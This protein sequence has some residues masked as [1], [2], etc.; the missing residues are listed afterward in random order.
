LRYLKAGQ[1]RLRTSVYAEHGISIQELEQRLASSEIEQN[2][3]TIKL[4][5]LISQKKL[6]FTVMTVAL[7]PIMREL[8]S[9]PLIMTFVVLLKPTTLELVIKKFLPA[10]SNEAA[11]SF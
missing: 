10:L 2:E 4:A 7:K 3:R 11:I 6:P 1:E 5:H 9:L 8:T